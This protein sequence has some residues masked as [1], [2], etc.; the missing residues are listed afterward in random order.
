MLRLLS[1]A[2]W[3]FGTLALGAAVIYPIYRDVSLN[4]VRAEVAAAVDTIA[5]GQKVHF[6]LR[7][8]FVFFRAG[9]H[10]RLRTALVSLREQPVLERPVPNFRFEALSDQTHALIIRA[11]PDDQAMRAGKL[12]PMLYRYQVAQPGQLPNRNQNAEGS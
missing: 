12:P 3:L 4:R 11:F 5:K 6:D 1:S 8:E 7:D 2:F 9:E 10:D